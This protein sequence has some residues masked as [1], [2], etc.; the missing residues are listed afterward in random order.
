MSKNSLIEIIIHDIDA[1]CILKSNELLIWW[2]LLYYILK[3]EIGLVFQMKIKEK[4]SIY[5]NR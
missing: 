4:N 3:G 5:K 2:L 1:V